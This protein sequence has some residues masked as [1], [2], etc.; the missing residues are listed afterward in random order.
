[1]KKIL[2]KSIVFLLVLTMIWSVSSMAMATTPQEVD[3]A[4]KDTAEY[5]YKT[6]KSPQVGSIGGEWAVISLARSG[7]NIPDEYYQKYY[8]TVE[9]YVKACKG[10]LHDKKY[11]E[12]SRLIVALT[13]IGKDPSNVAGYNLLTA[14]GDY[15]KTIWQG[16]NGPIWALI[17]LD[18][19]NYAMPQNP[20]AKKQATRDMYVQRILECQLPD[21]GWS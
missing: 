20:K 10:E 5:M 4:I 16:L 8:K 14:L 19:G 3:A 6:V 18:S 7:Y 13:A 12:Y 2:Q 1:M 21:G 17:S 15:D 9:D 11:T